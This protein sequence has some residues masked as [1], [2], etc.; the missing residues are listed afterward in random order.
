MQVYHFIRW[1][2][3]N[4]R[5]G[6]ETTQGF[7]VHANSLA[8]AKVIAVQSLEQ[9]IKEGSFTNDSY[10]KFHKKESCLPFVDCELCQPPKN[11]LTWQ[12]FEEL[13]TSWFT[14]TG[15]AQYGTLNGQI[16]K[17]GEEFGEIGQAM[18]K[19]DKDLLRDAIGDTCVTV[20]S[21]FLQIK[22]I[23]NFSSQTINYYDCAD[24]AK[25]LINDFDTGDINIYYLA[26]SAISELV[27]SF[28]I[29]T[30]GPYPQ[31]D[32]IYA[33]LENVVYWLHVLAKIKDLTLGECLAMAWNEIKDRSGHM[34]EQGV[35][36]KD[37]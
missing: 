10:M 11:E 6:Q 37:E 33:K 18:G 13:V 35:F 29:K 5:D 20:V 19:G 27:E 28:L 31:T 14:H 25:A 30:E 21:V 17:M 32:L 16:Y 23:H 1:I 2:T 9:K 15:I 7:S 34:N 3:Q 22:K 8:E 24:R 12:E 4:T 36:V 26:M